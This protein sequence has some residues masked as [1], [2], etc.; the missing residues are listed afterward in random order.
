[1]RPYRNITILVVVFISTILY[2]TISLAGDCD[3]CVCDKGT[4]KSSCTACCSKLKMDE[5]LNKNQVSAQVQAE[6]KP[7]RCKRCLEYRLECVKKNDKGEC[8][9]WNYKCVQEETYPCKK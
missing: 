6:T 9:E 8:I 5:N 7:D 4:V 3:Y 2:V 1:M